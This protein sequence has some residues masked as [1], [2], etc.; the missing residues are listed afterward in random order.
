MILKKVKN[1]IGETAIEYALLI[2]LIGMV[3]FASLP[4]LGK[5]VSYVF[6]VVGDGLISSQKCESEN[7]INNTKWRIDKSYI[8]PSLGG[9]AKN[10]VCWSCDSTNGEVGNLNPS[11]ERQAKKVASALQK[12]K[13]DNDIAMV[14]GVMDGNKALTSYKD[15]YDAL[16]RASQGDMNVKNT[17]GN[18]GSIEVVTSNGEGYW[19]NTNDNQFWDEGQK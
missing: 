9:T 2:M 10:W 1:E 11:L 8:D 16:I 18:Y 15:S 14:Y 4:L 7:L 19:F 5:N 17:G 3:C 6:C 12:F 13:Q